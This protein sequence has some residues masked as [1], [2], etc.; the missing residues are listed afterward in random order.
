[1]LLS[2]VIVNY[3]SKYR[4]KQCIDAI[5]TYPPTCD[6]EILVVD[7]HSTDGSCDFLKDGSYAS[8]RLVANPKPMGY[9][10]AANQGF[11]LSKGNRILFLNPDIKVLEHSIDNMMKHMEEDES[12]GAVAGYYVFPDGRFH[13][14]YNRFPT[15]FSF[16]LACFFPK[17][18]ALFRSYK[19]YHMLDTDFSAA[20]EVPQPAGGCL[21]IRKELFKE[22]Y[23]SP[24]FCIFFSDVEVCKKIYLAGRRIMVFPDCKVIHDHDYTGRS[25]SG[26]SYFYA[27][28]LYIGC[29]NYFRIYHGFAGFITIKLLF[30]GTLLLSALLSL[31][32]C[33]LGKKPLDR[34]KEK[35]RI[36]HCFLLHRNILLEHSA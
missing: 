13:K 15:V 10:H 2:I 5:E 33:L 18:G 26:V 22:R 30:A 21:L 20:V 12:L 31:G 17:M 14:Y 34:A 35:F 8:V 24:V 3:N 1:M 7:N 16:Y 6:F 9:T 32:K 29:A 11:S 28:D 23:M 19:Q 36:F 27:L 25:N 4:L